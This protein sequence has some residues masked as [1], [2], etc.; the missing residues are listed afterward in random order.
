MSASEFL[1][2]FS[3][4]DVSPLERGMAES[5]RQDAVEAVE[6]ERQQAEKQVAAETRAESMLLAERQLGSPLAEMSRA[7]AAYSAADDEVA[8]LAARLQKATARRDSA[9][10]NLEFFASRAQQAAGLASRSAPDAIGAAVTRAQEALREEASVRRV[11][12]MLASR[13]A[14]RA[15][16]RPFV[17]RG[18]GDGHF[19]VPGCPDCIKA[20]ATAEESVLI[21]LDPRPVS[22]NTAAATEAERLLQGRGRVIYR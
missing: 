3:A 22:D 2:Q 10:R 20:G 6:A 5:A 15:G 11:E 16:R 8:D 17:S 21:H 9:Q 7:R 18:L 13:T 14:S 4:G 19:D 1:E 12:R